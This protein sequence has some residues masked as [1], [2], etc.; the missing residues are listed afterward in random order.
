M[1][2]KKTKFMYREKKNKLFYI[3]ERSNSKSWNQKQIIPR[4]PEDSIFFIISKVQIY[5]QILDSVPTLSEL[6]LC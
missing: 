5:F 3:K 1:K 6:S 4:T 2:Q